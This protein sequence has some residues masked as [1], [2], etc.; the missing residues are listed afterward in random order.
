MSLQRGETPGPARRNPSRPTPASQLA[1]RGSRNPA[2]V[3]YIPLAELPVGGSGWIG[4][5]RLRIH[6]GVPGVLARAEVFP[7]QIGNPIE[8]RRTEQGLEVVIPRNFVIPTS[9]YGLNGADP[10]IP[11][12]VLQRQLF[13]HPR[14]LG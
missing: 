8:I 3:R 4:M 7:S 14:E 6:D 9:P 10:A 5:T 13:H 11:V 12:K 1:V 2:T